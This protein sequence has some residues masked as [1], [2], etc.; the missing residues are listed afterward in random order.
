M[1]TSLH[2]TCHL[3]IFLHPFQTMGRDKKI[4][5]PVCAATKKNPRANGSRLSIHQQHRNPQSFV[6]SIELERGKNAPEVIIFPQS[7]RAGKCPRQRK[8]VL[9]YFTLVFPL[10]V[11]EINVEMLHNALMQFARKQALW[12]S[13]YS[14]RICHRFWNNT[15]CPLEQQVR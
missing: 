3:F 4:I 8:N 7:A 2:R 1:N 15:V 13:D 14:Q 6:F 5:I 10:R 11:I 12:K 9:T